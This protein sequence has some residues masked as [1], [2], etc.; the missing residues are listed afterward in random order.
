MVPGGAIFLW[1]R[2]SSQQG[3]NQLKNP[4]CGLISL[5]KISQEGFALSIVLLEGNVQTLGFS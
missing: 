2:E 3:P 4:S 5:S 1:N